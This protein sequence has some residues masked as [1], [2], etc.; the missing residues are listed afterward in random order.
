VGSPV[1]MISSSSPFVRRAFFSEKEIKGVHNAIIAK[2]FFKKTKS[3]AANAFG[4][5][6]PTVC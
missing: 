4:G 2:I 5:L 3:R 6:S 1:R